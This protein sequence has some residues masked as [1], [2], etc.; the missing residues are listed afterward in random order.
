[1]TNDDFLKHFDKEKYEREIRTKD[2]TPLY[3]T[4]QNVRQV[5]Q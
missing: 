1:M 4:K 2:G 5:D 3:F